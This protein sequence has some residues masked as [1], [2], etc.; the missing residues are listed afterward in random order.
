MSS[1]AISSSTSS[2]ADAAPGNRAARWIAGALAVAALL[3]LVGT[4]ARYTA[5]VPRGD[6]AISVLPFLAAWSEAPGWAEK[7]ALLHGQHFS[8]RIVLTHL[9]ALA[10]AVR[11]GPFDFRTLQAFGVIAWVGTVLLV[12][13]GAPVVRTAPWSIPALCLLLF[14][15]S[16]YSNFLSG[17]QAVQNLGMAALAALACAL[18]TTNR[19]AATGG[20]LALAAFAPLVSANGLLLAPVL[21]TL[22]LLTGAR[23]RAA[24]ALVAGAAG[25][26]AFAWGYAWPETAGAPL[27]AV[28]N[29]VVMA[30][31][32]AH[33]SWSGLA[34][35]RLIGTLLLAVAIAALASRAA[36]R[37]QPA[38]AALLLFC[39]LSIF[40]AG[41]GRDGID[42]TYMLQDRYLLHGLLTAAL[43]G[44]LVLDRVDP[45]RRPRASAVALAAAA[46]FATH[47]YAAYVPL[48]ATEHRWV[49]ATAINRQLGG[50][51]LLASG[52]DWRDFEAGLSA[53]ERTGVYAIPPKLPS[54]VIDRLRERGDASDGALEF[55]VQG[56]SAA[57]G[58]T[59]HPPAD[60]NLDATPFV[61]VAGPS[62]RMVL[63]LDRRRAAWSHI[64]AGR[65]WWHPA[66][67][68]VW[69]SARLRPG[70]HHVHGFVPAKDAI[71]VRWSG[72]VAANL[73]P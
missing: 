34:G 15:P 61:L 18:A 11:P 47:A 68:Y 14:Q 37:R 22:W 32:F 50:T 39:V 43:A 51:F 6:D 42:E 33:N 49:H 59:L 35:T 2:T 54:T 26:T 28:H 71:D 1:T 45:A 44:L 16:G 7:V 20:A 25:W 62:G 63:P 31:G 69:P 55:E 52:P 17:M 67:A 29:A 27:Q 13:R 3:L 9:V 4:L 73:L 36:W 60:S 64:L 72:T 38:T 40:M 5:N 21:A 10:E 41:K 8:H 66:P 65:G 56:S 48:L 12:L 57:L 70:L 19:R 58:A 53:A 30:G 23:G 46:L 24:A